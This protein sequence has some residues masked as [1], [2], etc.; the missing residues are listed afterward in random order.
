MDSNRKTAIIVG[1]LF[2]IAT[3]TSSLGYNVILPPILKTPDYLS[4]VFENENQV[5]TGVLL[6]LINCA[7]VV[8]IPIMLF[9]I[10]KKHNKSLALGYAG[11]RIIESV[12]IIAGHF[13]LLSLLTLSQEYVKEA[14]GDA[15]YF[16][17][18]GTLLLAISDWSWL[19]GVEIVFPIGALLLN[20]LLY[21]SK[22]VPRFISV[23]GII[24]AILLLVS[25]FLAMFG[26]SPPS[27]VS[28]FL[29]IPIA[30][31]EMVLAV[32][33][34]GK[35]FNLSAIASGSAE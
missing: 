14:S 9:P 18:L 19:L 27:V 23:W 35:G 13:I 5:I 16:Q 3:V 20:Y 30:L 26:F 8:A 24:G 28:M 15:S 10:F 12:T 4:N 6:D 17:T 2:I 22:L 7:A 33:L 25:G 32:W 29:R 34:I 31:N 11:T 1:V 21:Q